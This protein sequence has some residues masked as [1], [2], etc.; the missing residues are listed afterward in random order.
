MQGWKAGQKLTLLDEL[1]ETRWRSEGDVVNKCSN[2]GASSPISY[3]AKQGKTRHIKTLIK[4]GARVGAEGRSWERT[5]A[6]HEAVKCDGTRKSDV[7]PYTGVVPLALDCIRLLLR[8]PGA[9]Q[10][11]SCTN[12]EGLTPR[13]LALKLNKREVADLLVERP[14]E[15]PGQR[16]AQ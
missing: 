13:A 15:V 1:L 14:A 10:A 2:L 16:R 9:A 12:S 8:A 6:L 7:Y 3:A 11:L 4:H 5:T